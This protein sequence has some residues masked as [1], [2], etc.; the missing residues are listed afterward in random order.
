MYCLSCDYNLS[1]AAQKT[2]PECGRTFD[3]DDPT[4]FGPQ[5]I[6]KVRKQ[7][8]IIGLTAPIIL[9]LIIW[10]SSQTNGASMFMLASLVGIYG[11]IALLVGIQFQKH[12]PSL[13]LMCIAALPALF[14][15]GLFYSLAINMYQSLGGWPNTIGDH[16]FS[17]QLK[18]HANLALGYFAVITL[19]N[20]F[21]LP[22]V[23]FIFL[24]FS[25][26]RELLFLLGIYAFMN[27]L[28]L[29]LIDLAPRQFLYWWWD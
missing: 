12:R 8:V 25:K 24:C 11:L 27:A 29:G 9:G 18:I 22:I 17:S 14:M 13:W 21:I 16:G 4:S 6:Q 26:G 28:S 15:L 20:I 7:Q 10:A 19:F 1:G 2:C 3:P 5:P 23:I